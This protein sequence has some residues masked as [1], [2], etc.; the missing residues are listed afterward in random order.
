MK[1]TLRFPPQFFLLFFVGVFGAT[2]FYLSVM[3]W[4]S[5]MFLLFVPF[6]LLGAG[7]T[8]LNCAGVLLNIEVEREPER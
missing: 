6:F 7:Q 3:V 8:L 5:Q 4:R 2:G 1:V